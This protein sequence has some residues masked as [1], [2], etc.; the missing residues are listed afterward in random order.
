MAALEYYTPLLIRVHTDR[1]EA[2][3][4]EGSAYSAR[5]KQL[6]AEIKTAGGIDESVPPGFYK[7]N[8]VPW[9]G[10]MKIVLAPAGFN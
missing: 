9:N 10:Q 6:I 8:M 7:L 4:A 5:E 3:P 1:W 2:I